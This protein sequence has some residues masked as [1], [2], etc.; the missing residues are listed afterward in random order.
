MKK[1]LT[2]LTFWVLTA[3]TCGILL[4]HF[5]PEIALKQVLPDDLK[6]RFLGQELKIGKSLSEAFGGEIIY[7]SDYIFD[8][9][10]WHR[11]YGRSQES[12]K[13]WT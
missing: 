6:G 10:A 9:Y 12:R 13:G 2:N 8:H 4:G 7:Q 11:F 1:I 3:I 5:F